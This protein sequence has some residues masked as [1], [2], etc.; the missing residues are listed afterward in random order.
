MSYKLQWPTWFTH[1]NVFTSD[2]ICSNRPT[3]NTG[4]QDD[5]FTRDHKVENDISYEI[6]KVGS[7]GVG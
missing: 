7:M 2:F 3:D 1:F 4:S 6:V 5:L